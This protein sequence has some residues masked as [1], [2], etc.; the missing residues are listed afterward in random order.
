[1]SFVDLEHVGNGGYHGVNPTFCLFR[2]K[3]KFGASSSTRRLTV[4]ER[5]VAVVREPEE[6]RRAHAMKIIRTLYAKKQ[7]KLKAETHKRMTKYN[8]LVEEA[9]KEKIDRNKKLQKAV[10]R[11]LS[12]QDAK[13]AKAAKNPRNAKKGR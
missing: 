7:E 2:D 3:P 5:R 11:D 13:D 4:Q 8:K 10:F 6:Q 12:K 1:M 9:T